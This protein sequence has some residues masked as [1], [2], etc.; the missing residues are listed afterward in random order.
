MRHSRDSDQTADKCLVRTA[1][2]FTSEQLRHIS[3]SS[4]FGRLSLG[5]RNLPLSA[6]ARQSLPGSARYRTDVVGS[7]D[8]TERSPRR[9]EA[10]KKGEGCRCFHHRDAEGR[11]KNR[12]PQLKRAWPAIRC[13]TPPLECRCVLRRAPSLRAS[14]VNKPE[15][16]SRQ[17]LPAPVFSPSCLRGKRRDTSS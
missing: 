9:L 5:G 3:P 6:P 11:R 15:A 2:I 14:V 12:G 17:S 16:G 8:A 4:P 1:Q 13:A 10:V 7:P